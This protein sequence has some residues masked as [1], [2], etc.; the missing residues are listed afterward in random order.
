MPQKQSFHQSI[1]NTP[2]TTMG[3]LFSSPKPP[4]TKYYPDFVKDKIPDLSG[5]TVAITGCTSGTGFIFAKTAITKNVQTILLLN[6][7]SDR[8]TKAETELKSFIPSGSSCH[9]ETIP[10]DLQDLSSVRK[11]TEHIV[12]KFQSIDVLVNNAGVMALDDIATKDGFDIQMQTNHLSHFLITKNLYPLLRRAAELH[13]EARV[14]THSSSAR[15]GTKRVEGK[16]YEKNGGNLG[17][18]STGMFAGGAV[19]VRYAQSKLANSLFAYE[20][21]KKCDALAASG[22]P[23]IKSVCCTP[24]ASLTNLQGGSGMTSFERWMLAVMAQSGE[25]GTMPLLWVSFGVD[26]EN[27]D[28]YEPEKMGKNVGL[29]KK[30]PIEEA[31]TKDPEDRA[32]AWSK[33][34]EAVGGKFVVE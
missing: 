14:V 9:V 12:S 17:G 32:L 34:E 24:G 5:K 29:P 25:D 31:N 10:C 28:F 6:R 2:P 8:A 33:S 18:N 15:A 16:Y 4:K 22:G 21:S 11:A 27:G 3:L 19:W 20:L 26:V 1:L 13:G 7:P 30:F 23:K